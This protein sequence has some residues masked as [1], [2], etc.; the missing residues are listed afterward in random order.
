MVNG[1]N[2]NHARWFLLRNDLTAN[3][4]NPVHIMSVHRGDEALTTIGSGFRCPPS[5][6]LHLAVKVTRPGRAQRTSPEAIR[7]PR[8]PAPT[9]G[10]LPAR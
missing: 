4:D 2:V 7:K 3:G 1:A 8:G 10:A 5:P 9:R 6:L